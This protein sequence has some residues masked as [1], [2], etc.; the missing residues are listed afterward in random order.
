MASTGAAT[1]EQ[2]PP[3]R[4]SGVSIQQ[5]TI[6]DLARLD[7]PDA[8]NVAA[9]IAARE[10]VGIARY[11]TA[12]FPHNG[13][14]PLIDAY[15]ESLDLA[16]YLRQAIAEGVGVARELQV[17]LRLACSLRRRIGGGHAAV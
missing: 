15:Q 14:S 17:T 9:D 10:K 16:V 13:R 6:A 1:V 7:D 12:L 3:T 11:G 5:L 8:P 2:S 4:G